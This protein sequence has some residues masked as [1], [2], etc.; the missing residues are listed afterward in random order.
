[1]N[2]NIKQFLLDTESS[3]YKLYKNS[4][5]KLESEINNS[6][7]SSKSVRSTKLFYTI[8]SDLPFEEIK[9]ILYGKLFLIM[10]YNGMNNQHTR[11]SVRRGVVCAASP[12]LHWGIFNKTI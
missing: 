9:N 10:S 3:I 7:N 12:S 2:N 4:I 8:L 11:H 5:V 1:M 6:T